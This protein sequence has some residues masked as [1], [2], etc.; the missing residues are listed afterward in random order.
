MRRAVELGSSNAQTEL[1][2]WY[3]DGECGLPTN[4]KEA[5]RLA[6]LGA[7]AGNAT[8]MN[9]IGLLFHEGWGVATD[10]DQAC[11]WNREATALGLEGAKYNLRN[12][13]RTGHAPSIAAVRDLGLGPL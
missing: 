2:R 7:E 13:A 9:H 11:K 12:L 10:F 8:A 1:A 3:V 4:Y 6:K 5:M